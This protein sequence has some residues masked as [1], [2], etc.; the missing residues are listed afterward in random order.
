MTNANLLISQTIQILWSRIKT[1]HFSE[2]TSLT[3]KKFMAE[4]ESE[5]YLF[6]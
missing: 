1:E 5:A 6:E 3:R 2:T 4:N